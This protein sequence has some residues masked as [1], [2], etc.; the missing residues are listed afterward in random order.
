[1]E[2][3]DGVK[4]V[5]FFILNLIIGYMFIIWAWTNEPH[6][7]VA[8]G[9]F[10]I[11]VS[12]LIF[13]RPELADWPSYRKLVSS[14][15]YRVQTSRVFSIF[16]IVVSIFA[17]MNFEIT[18]TV[19]FGIAVLML[20]AAA[21]L[22]ALIWL[23]RLKFGRGIKKGELD[24]TSTYILLFVS[25]LSI[26]GGIYFINE[27]RPFS[28]RMHNMYGIIIAATVGILL[29]QL[30]LRTLGRGLEREKSSQA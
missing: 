29:G 27:N 2:Q 19:H 25:A 12:L 26:A 18:S 5:V 30:V 11:I 16:L 21:L 20:G 4:G 17:L 7:A 10:G 14:K 13:I 24:N 8:T 6:L 1:M 28:L 15:E 3:K 23:A 9:I 22:N